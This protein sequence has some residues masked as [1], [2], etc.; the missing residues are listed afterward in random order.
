MN[1]RIFLSKSAAGLVVISWPLSACNT[2]PNYDPAMVAE[3]LDL[4]KIWDT[5]T[6]IKIGNL[7]REQY[8]KENERSLVKKIAERSPESIGERIQEDFQS[9]RT[10]MLDGWTLSMTEARQCA[11]FSIKESK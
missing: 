3:P 6:I 2:G 8:P 7:Y 9:G 5:E 10:I 4:S 1:R 11:L